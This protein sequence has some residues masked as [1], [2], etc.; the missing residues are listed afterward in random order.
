MWS[1]EKLYPSDHVSIVAEV[2]L[3]PDRH[4]SKVRPACGEVF[5]PHLNI[6]C[7]K[8]IRS[9]PPGT[10]LQLQVV[11]TFRDGGRHFLYSSH[12]WPYKVL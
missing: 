1:R 10:R 3:E 5:P 7:C 8:R 2:I 11:E 12:E 6:E 4:R 9:L